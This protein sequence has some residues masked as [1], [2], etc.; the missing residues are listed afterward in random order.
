M[1]KPVVI[2][3]RMINIVEKSDAGRL[4]RVSVAELKLKVKG[5]T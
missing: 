4:E 5:G 3:E 1:K 2:E